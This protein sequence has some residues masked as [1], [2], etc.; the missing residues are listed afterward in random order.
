MHV[1]MY[2]F[3]F[4]FMRNCKIQTIETKSPGAFCN[5]WLHPS[6]RSDLERRSWPQLA[7]HFRLEDGYVHDHPHEH[8]KTCWW[9]AKLWMALIHFHLTILFTFRAVSVTT[10]KQNTY[11]KL[12]RQHRPRRRTAGTVVGWYELWSSRPRRRRGAASPRRRISLTWW[13]RLMKPKNKI[14]LR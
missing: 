6:L 1:S 10:M 5:C 4:F 7:A 11:R 14:T 8:Q 3:L 13:R 9:N 12:W 2:V